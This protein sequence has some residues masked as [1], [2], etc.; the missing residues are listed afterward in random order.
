MFSFG[1]VLR[2]LLANVHLWE[3][4]NRWWNKSWKKS[5][6]YVHFIITLGIKMLHNNAKLRSVVL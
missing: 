3:K 4:V 2:L 1:V 6:L 5:L